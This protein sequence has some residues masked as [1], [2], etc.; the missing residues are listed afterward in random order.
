MMS[1]TA[2]SPLLAQATGDDPDWIMVGFVK[3]LTMMLIAGLDAAILIGGVCLIHV[4]FSLPLRRSE[5]ARLFLDLLDG[6][7]KRDRKSVV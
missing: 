6:A 5:R 4:L 7:L 2:I 1:V 3:F